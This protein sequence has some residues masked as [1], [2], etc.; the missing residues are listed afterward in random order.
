MQR[1]ALAA[2]SCVLLAMAAP[3]ASTADPYLDDMRGQAQIYNPKH[4]TISNHTK[5]GRKAR[6]SRAPVMHTADA[7]NPRWIGV[8]RGYTGTNPTK[9]RSLWCA[10][11]MNLVLERSGMKG[12][13]SSMAV[14]FAS[15]GQRISGPRVGA[16]A[17]ISRGRG[18]SHVGI[19][20]GVD[21]KGN[22]MIIS[23]NHNNTV[24]EAP[25]PARSVMAYVWP[26]G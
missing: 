7:G 5:L 16:I 13:S 17:V 19:V 12:T 24:A 21:S 9:R 23:G 18:A 15:Y 26:A 2:M 6:A 10:D 8:A 4:T 22:P 1:F 14:S 11:F 25:Y 3:N 20:T